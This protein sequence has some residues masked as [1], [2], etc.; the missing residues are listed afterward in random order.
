MTDIAPRDAIPRSLFLFCDPLWRH[1]ARLAGVLGAKQ[2]RNWSAGGRGRDLSVPD[3]GRG[4]E[5]DCRTAR[6]DIANRMVR[7]GFVPLIHGDWR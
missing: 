6:Q 7:Y 5:R 1:G 3:A 2:V 4:I